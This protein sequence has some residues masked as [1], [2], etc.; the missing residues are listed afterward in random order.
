MSEVYL[1]YTTS[2]VGYLHSQAT[3][4]TLINV[5]FFFLLLLFI[6]PTFG[7]GLA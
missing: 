5:F 1:L 2:E 7:P 4:I 3:A 6:T